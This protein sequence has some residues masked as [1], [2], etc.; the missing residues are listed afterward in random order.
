MQAPITLKFE[1]PNKYK[2]LILKVVDEVNVELEHQDN[3]LKTLEH[4]LP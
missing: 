2:Y 4:N 1:V 3:D